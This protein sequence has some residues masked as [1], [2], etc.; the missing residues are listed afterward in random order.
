M[1]A[2]NKVSGNKITGNKVLKKKYPKKRRKKTKKK[3]PKSCENEVKSKTFSWKRLFTHLYFEYSHGCFNYY[4][5][6]L[7]CC[8]HP[9]F[10]CI[11]YYN[12]TF[13]RGRFCMKSYWSQKKKFYENKVSNWSDFISGDFL[14]KGLFS[15]GLF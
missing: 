5:P 1:G 13:F 14:I 7:H 3:S 8:K 2:A 11:F 15:S 10:T 4:C 6:F 12:R 9:L